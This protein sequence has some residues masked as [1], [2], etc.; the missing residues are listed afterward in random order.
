MQG[1]YTHEMTFDQAHGKDNTQSGRTDF[2]CRT[3]K[4]ESHLL[5]IT[6]ERL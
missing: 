6:R 3:T 2:A 1:V 4:E 5:S